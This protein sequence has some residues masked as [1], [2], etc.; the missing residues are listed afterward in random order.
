MAQALELCVRAPQKDWKVKLP[1]DQRFGH[2][3]GAAC[4]DLPWRL[5]QLSLND[6]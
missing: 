1:A 2:V 3:R 6:R 5:S 4:S